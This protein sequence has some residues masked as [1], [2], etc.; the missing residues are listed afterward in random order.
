MVYSRSAAV[1]CCARAALKRGQAWV[2]PLLPLWPPNFL[3][4]Y[5][6]VGGHPPLPPS[7]WEGQS[8]SLKN[9]GTWMNTKQ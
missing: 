9:T 8:F 1:L 6:V 2:W 7:S 4:G 5:K 3:F